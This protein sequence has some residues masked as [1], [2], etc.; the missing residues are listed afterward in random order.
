MDDCINDHHY[1][2][3]QPEW[4]QELRRHFNDYALTGWSFS[5]EAETIEDELFG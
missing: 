5:D 3:E 2:R 4:A 1:W